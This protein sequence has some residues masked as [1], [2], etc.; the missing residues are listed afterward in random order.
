[1]LRARARWAELMAA[2]VQVKSIE[3]AMRQLDGTDGAPPGPDAD[4][5]GTGAGADGGKPGAEAAASLD[6]LSLQEEAGA[7]AAAPVG[8]AEGALA[9]EGRSK[10]PQGALDVLSVGSMLVGGIK[11]PGDSRLAEGRVV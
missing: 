3:E 4:G 9:A 2:V 8:G 10:L 7:S 6:N 1:V 11:I 5:R